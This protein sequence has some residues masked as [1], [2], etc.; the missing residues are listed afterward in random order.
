MIRVL[1]ERLHDEGSKYEN[2]GDVNFLDGGCLI[3][4]DD[5]YDGCY[6]VITCDL[7]YDVDSP[8]HY[9]IQECYVDINDN[10]IDVS[11]VEDY[12]GV[13]KESDPEWFA[14]ALV[15][16]YGGEEFGAYVPDRGLSNYDDV[17][18]TAEGV[19]EYMKQYNIPSDIY[20]DGE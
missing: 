4:K 13:S 7:V 3:A 9:L 12:S 17:L 15:R 11:A 19:E 8:H 14:E 18:Y 5:R 20:F 6:Y 10:W 1:G 16:Y 2:Y